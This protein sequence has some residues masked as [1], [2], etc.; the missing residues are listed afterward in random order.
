MINKEKVELMSKVALYEQGEGKTTL[1][2]NKYYKNDYS[3]AKLLSG[4]PLGILSGLLI[5][6]LIFIA[7]GDWIIK[8]YDSL[9]GVVCVVVLVLAFSVFVLAY[10][11]FTV[12]MH[13]KK[14]D[15][16]RGNLKNYW[17][18]LKRLDKVYEMSKQP[19]DTGTKT[20][21]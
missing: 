19:E 12:Y 4:V 17:L 5:I 20:D 14:Y 8:A 21:K 7:D 6:L 2:L 13:N 10:S 9:G 18:N 11:F 3:S 1:K 15:K 16:Y